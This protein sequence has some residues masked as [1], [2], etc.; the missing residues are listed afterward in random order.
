M[1][2]RK[3]IQTGSMAGLSLSM[4]GALGETG[5]DGD[6]SSGKKNMIW[7]FGDQHRAQA[8]GYMGDTNARTPFLNDLSLEGTTFTN[9]VSGCP[10][11]TPFR[12]SLYTSKYNHQCVYRTPQHL[13][14]NL[15]LVTD[16]F[17]DNGY[18]TAFF[19]KWHLFGHN[20]REFVPR[21]ERGRFGIWLGYE[22]NNAQ[23][24]SWIHGHDNRGRDDK[25]TD[26]QKL[27]KYETD[28]LTDLLIDFITKRQTDKPFFAVLSVQP[29][30]D[31]FVAPP[32]YMANFDAN[33]IKLRPNVPDND[34][35]K[36][37]YRKNLAGYY[38]QIENLDFNVGRIISALKDLKL[39]SSTN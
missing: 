12:G 35:W 14:K 27:E 10:W 36:Q 26:T 31:P 22:N 6:N 3:F 39:E 18:L 5:T 7:I 20:K 16:V 23:Y 33:G 9:A 1:E 17:N 25:K 19:G 8:L 4:K 30:H 32:E 28:A 37:K 29:P 2:R 24:D 13:D 34:E 38:A 11:C 21:E 15:P